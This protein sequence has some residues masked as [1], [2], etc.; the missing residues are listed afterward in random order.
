MI[1]VTGGAGYI[2]SHCVKLLLRQGYEV[3][4]FD[5]LSEGSREAVL[6]DHFVHGDLL[7]IQQL[8]QVFS[9]Y[10][11]EAVMHFA[12]LIRVGES[13][14]APDLYYQN[15]VTATVNLL[16]QMHIH[17]IRR[18]IFS[19][20]AAV[21]GSPTRIPIPEDAPKNPTSVYGR[22]KWLAEQIMSD[23]AVAYGLRYVALRYFNAAGCD[24]E[25][26]LGEN[27]DPETHL[28]PLVLDV[29]LGKRA[30]I[31]VFGSDYNTHDGTCIRDYIH[32]QD[33]ARAH[34][35]TLEALVG[36][37]PGGVYNLGLMT[38]FSV[39]EVI[40]VCRRVTGRQITVVEAERRAGDPAELVADSTRF[41]REF[42]WVPEIVT[43][44]EMVRTAWAYRV[45][46]DVVHDG[47]GK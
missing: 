33:I 17:D 23:Y 46:S 38:G 19:S 2:G 22:T 30:D 32:V 35:R 45:E 42:G 44:D 24:P 9:T 13:M 14:S 7:D 20:S 10:P 41:R 1:L 3:V 15:N 40:D 26:Q 43:L 4:A 37:H 34:V 5:N 8:G 18:L 28:I 16:S 12:G 6:S 31:Q 39:R 25:G 47:R 11:I 36:G 21:Y 27:H 29:A